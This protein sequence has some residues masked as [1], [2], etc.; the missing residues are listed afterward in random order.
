[1][2]IS[3]LFSDFDGTISP[4]DVSREEAGILPEIRPLL[5]KIACLVPLAVIT[6]KDMGFIR[7][8]VPFAVAWAAIAGLDI[9][10]RY[11][12]VAIPG[13]AAK[14]QSLLSVLE[15]IR[16]RVGQ[17]EDNIYIEEK[18]VDKS[19]A[20]FCIDWR[21]S[22][23]PRRVREGVESLLSYCEQRGLW[24]VR[25][26]KS[27]FA[28]IYPVEVN[29]GIALA[30]VKEEL[31]AVGPV[32]YMGDSETDNPAFVLADVSIGVLHKEST[33]S[34]LKCSYFVRF[35]DM[36]R[37]LK[38]LLDSGLSFDPSFPAIMNGERIG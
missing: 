13:L 5:E 24:V 19:V 6:T 7:E 1:M 37:F 20:A 38:E 18:M 16:E 27:P 12:V 28:D 33:P 14:I 2:R 10:T 34:K 31:Q 30:K 9:R 25:Y 17:I 35:E 8:R 29:K 11:K 26:E 4:L 21:L 36:R 15:Y 22:Q 32:M 3:A 23:H